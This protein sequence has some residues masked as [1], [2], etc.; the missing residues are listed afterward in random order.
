MKELNF[1]G[2][3]IFHPTSLWLQKYFVPLIFWRLFS[4]IFPPLHFSQPVPFLNM[5]SQKCH[6]LDCRAQP[7]CSCW[8][9]HRTV[10]ATPHCCQHL[11]TNTQYTKNQRQA[12]NI[13]SIMIMTEILVS[14][15]FHHRIFLI[16][17][18]YTLEIGRG[19]KERGKGRKESER[20]KK[21]KDKLMESL[22]YSA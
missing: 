4:C 8:N 5:L 21:K 19:V 17:I 1:S 7:W 15:D 2:S 16:R 11:S 22:Q 10:L 3:H 14:R 6:N 9:Q 20:N 18:L 12:K 13:N